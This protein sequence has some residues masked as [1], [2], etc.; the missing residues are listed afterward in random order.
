LRRPFTSSIRTSFF[1]FSPSN[2]IPGINTMKIKVKRNTMK[3]K[4]K[5]NTTKIKR[6]KER[7]QVL[8]RW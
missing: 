2:P 5:R 1:S 3:I 7:L 6:R 8:K 4:V